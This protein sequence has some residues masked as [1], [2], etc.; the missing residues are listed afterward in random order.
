MGVK[1]Y[2]NKNLWTEPDLVNLLKGC[3]YL[4]NQEVE[5]KPG[6]D[7]GDTISAF[8]YSNDGLILVGISN[9]ARI[10]GTSKTEQD[11]CNYINS[12]ITP[13][14]F[15]DLFSIPLSKGG[16][17]IVMRVLKKGAICTCNGHYY[18]RIG[19]NDQL[20]NRTEMN[21]MLRHTE[22][23]DYSKKPFK[24]AEV[25]K[26][27]DEKR[28]ET[29]FELYQKKLGKKIDLPVDKFIENT[30]LVVDNDGLMKTLN[31]AGI[32]LFSKNPQEFI[33]HSKVRCIKIDGTELSS[34]IIKD[35]KECDGNLIEIIESTL[36]FIR[37]NIKKEAQ[38][39]GALT[40]Y[41]FEYPELAFREV[42][43]NA[44]IHRDYFEENLETKVLIFDNRIEV[45]SPGKFLQNCL[46]N[47]VPLNHYPRNQL[48]A[49]LM[50][51][52]EYGDKIGFG[53]R[54]ILDEMQ[55]R[56][57][58]LPTFNDESGSVIVTLWNKNARLDEI[59]N[60]F[61]LDGTQLKIIS[62]AVATGVVKSPQIS[63][64]LSISKNAAL[65]ELDK[66]IKLKLIKRK[67][68]GPAT[69]YVLSEEIR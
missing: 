13:S 26:Y 16:K 52:C 8:T 53:V 37:S 10:Q 64:I 31:A 66:L 35:E 41:K 15:F 29:F 28:F 6:L 62:I 25:R 1:E 20:L 63:E 19:E 61:D 39:V 49:E 68:K 18:K 59:A 55:K 42:I 7:F 27:F 67:G 60:A 51:K 43:I 4:E 17:V 69:R 34:P 44:V 47:G 2:I 36:D 54:R 30:C 12:K 40:D 5:F 21:E 65:R 32:L 3:T 38:V 24:A 23:Q 58:K 33:P 50:Q 22:N 56:G 11:I 9:D 46:E 45:R 57:R 48:I 14:P